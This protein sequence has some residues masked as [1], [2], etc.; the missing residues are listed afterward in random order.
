MSRALRGIGSR[1]RVEGVVTTGELTS[2]PEVSSLLADGVAEGGSAGDV[3]NGRG[4][5]MAVRARGPIKQTESLP[6]RRRK[7]ILTACLDSA[8]QTQSNYT[9]IDK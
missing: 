9:F 3:S 1:P 4:V 5:S 2:L 6:W 7:N 8:H